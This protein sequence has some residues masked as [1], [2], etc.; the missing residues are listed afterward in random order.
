MKKIICRQ[1]NNDYETRQIANIMERYGAEVFS[2]T[3]TYSTY[4]PKY[5]I[6][7]KVNEDFSFEKLHNSISS[8][9]YGMNYEV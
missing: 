9:V 3:F 1:T 8:E 2:I 4:N 7:A 5:H 6:W